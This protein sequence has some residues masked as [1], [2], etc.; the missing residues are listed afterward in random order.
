MALF[1]IKAMSKYRFKNE[2]EFKDDGLWNDEY[3]C[4]DE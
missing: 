3:E 4:P 1:Y 2:Q